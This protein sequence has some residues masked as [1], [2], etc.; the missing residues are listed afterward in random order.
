MLRRLTL[1]LLT[2][3]VAIAALPGIAAADH[4]D[5]DEDLIYL[6][7][8]DSLAMGSLRTNDGTT[9]VFPTKFSYTDRLH[10]ILQKKVD[11]DFRHVKL[12]CDGYKTTDM[13]VD[14]N[15][16]KCDYVTGTQL[17]DALMW[18]QTGDVALVTITVGANDINHLAGVCNFDPVCIQAGIPA[19]LGNLGFILN[20]LRT[21]GGYAGPIVGTQYY[22]PNVAAAAGFF[23]GAPGPLA[24][25][26]GFAFLSDALTQGLNAGLAYTYG[27]FGAPTADVYQAFKAG[28]FGDDG[29]RF[30]AE[31]N[32]IPDNADAACV[33]TS[34]CPEDPGVVANIHPT[35]Q[36]YKVMTSAFWKV[37]KQFDLAVAD[38]D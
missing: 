12:G 8:G 14:P 29:G 5:D 10:R 13:I 25:D 20:E 28:D 27:L 37:V 23:A 9:T 24:P 6:S 30:Q 7:L 11:R 18:L 38:D 22:N 2:M 17:G 4:D 34:M 33:L 35:R 32:G 1:M 21:T 19:F 16:G 3:A 36:G 15:D 26:L 31:G